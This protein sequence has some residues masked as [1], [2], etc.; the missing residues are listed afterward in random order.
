V[1]DSDGTIHPSPQFYARAM[2][3]L[4]KAQ[5]VVCRRKKGSKNREK[6]KRRV[7]R[8]HKKIARQRSH[9]MHVLSRNYANSHG[10]VIVESLQ[11]RNMTAMNKGL[12]RSILDASWGRLARYLRYKTEESG[13][14]FVV[15]DARYSS[16]T[17][18]ACETVDARSRK[19]QSE[20][21]CVS[22]G[23]TIHADINA[24]KVLKSR[25]NRSVLPVEGSVP[26]A[27][28]RSRKRTVIQRC[29]SEARVTDW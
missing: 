21:V 27:A 11:I 17:C 6:A 14:Q 19:T 18:H 28:R 20:F 2:R 16:Q 25:A 8:L 1:A 7:A 5:R 29:T 3:R 26:K 15:V 13:G 4:A 24:A 10:T 12:A 22:C 9:H 23:M